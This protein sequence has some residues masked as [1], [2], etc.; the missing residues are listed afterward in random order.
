MSTRAVDET[1]GIIATYDGEPINALYTSTCGG[2]TEDSENIF[3]QAVPYLRGRECAAEGIAAFERYVVKTTR[4]PAELR[5][6]SNVTIVRDVAL[7]LTQNFGSL[8]P[9]VTDTWLSGEASTADV[10]NWLTHA[11]RIARQPVPQTGEDVNRPPA[12]ATALAIAV[13]GE[14][15]TS[16]LMNNADADYL[17]GVRDAQSVPQDNRADLAMLVREGHLSLYPDASLRPR[18]P[19]SRARVIH[20]IARLLEARNLLQLQKANARPSVRRPGDPAFHERQGS[21]AAS[22]RRR[23]SVSTTRRASLRSFIRN[24]RR[25]RTGYLS[26]GAQRTDRLSRS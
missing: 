11:A 14:S 3:N 6:D 21:A 17:L 8:P 2:R 1:R 24:S 20:A 15:R 25:R 16:T 9:R 26:P 19:L 13:L 23:V 22:Q 18:E 12:F 4:D 5:D 7:L 10:R